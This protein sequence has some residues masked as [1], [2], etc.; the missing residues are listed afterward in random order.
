MAIPFVVEITVAILSTKISPVFGNL[1]LA[2][3]PALHSGACFGMVILHSASY[4]FGITTLQVRGCRVYGGERDSI[5]AL[6][7]YL[8]QTKRL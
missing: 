3:V 1:T 5:S 7:T 8:P 2:S 6:S 4:Q